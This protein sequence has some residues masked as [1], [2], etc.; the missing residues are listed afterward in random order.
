MPLTKKRGSGFASIQNLPCDSKFFASFLLLFIPE[1]VVGSGIS[2]FLT[3]SV[4][5]VA[6]TM[7]FQSGSCCC[8]HAMRVCI[9]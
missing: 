4:H 7:A 3:E 9:H 5:I 6:P 8:C 1:Q 2:L